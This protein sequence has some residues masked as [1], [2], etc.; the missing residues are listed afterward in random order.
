MTDSDIVRD[1]QVHMREQAL[2]KQSETYPLLDRAA[3]ESMV[4][5]AMEAFARK[6]AEREAL[7]QK[8]RSEMFER[9]QEV[10]SIPD[11]EELLP[12]HDADHRR[13]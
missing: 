4:R 8:S 3:V 2:V 7:R 9:F 13:T 11:C 12:D 1:M 5:S 10:I 6:H